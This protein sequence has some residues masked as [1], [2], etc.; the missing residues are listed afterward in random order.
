MDRMDVLAQAVDPDKVAPG[1]IGFLIIAALGA[2]TWMLMRSMN[3]QLKKI[4]FPPPEPG[5]EP[6]DEEPGRPAEP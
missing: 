4:D 6:D 5:D 1:T 2:A 3:K